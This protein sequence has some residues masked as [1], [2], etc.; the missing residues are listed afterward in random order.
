MYPLST[1]TSLGTQ[2]NPYLL[3]SDI[4]LV[5]PYVN[6]RVHLVNPL[7]S[8]GYSI[9][10]WNGV[11]Y[12]LL[13]D[14]T[15]ARWGNTD[16]SALLDLTATA[17]TPGTGV[18]V[19]SSAQLIPDWMT[20]DG[21]EI[22][23]LGVFGVSDPSSTAV[24]HVVIRI[25]DAAYTGTLD[26]NNAMAGFATASSTILRGSSQAFASM[27]ISSGSILGPLGGSVAA[28]AQI[29]RQLGYLGNAA[30]RRLRVSFSPASTTTRL[31]FFSFTI[32]TGAY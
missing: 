6:H 4:P 32:K 31:Q 29:R 7:V 23:T 5:G 16:G 3:Y 11:N 13:P 9:F 15:I 28:T 30:T 27:Q 14:Q 26:G 18:E 24:T 2:F 17:L 25:F 10:F 19:W 20:S 22:M 12:K 1:D 8:S 21:S